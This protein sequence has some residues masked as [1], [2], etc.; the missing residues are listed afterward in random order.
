MHSIKGPGENDFF[1]P[2][3]THHCLVQADGVILIFSR[4]MHTRPLSEQTMVSG[5][6]GRYA[7]GYL[8]GG[9]F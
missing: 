3:F 5:A 4:Q 6:P 7:A 8:T 2:G 9:L 1:G